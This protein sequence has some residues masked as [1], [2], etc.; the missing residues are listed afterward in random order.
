VRPVEIGPR[1]RVAR[2]VV[3]EILAVERVDDASVWTRIVRD[4]VLV[5][6]Q[7]FKPEFEVGV[8]VRAVGHGSLIAH[9]TS[10]TPGFSVIPFQVIRPSPD[11]SVERAGSCGP[12]RARRCSLPAEAE[13]V[14]DGLLVL[15]D[16]Q[17][18][19]CCLDRGLPAFAVGKRVGRRRLVELVGDSDDA[20]DVVDEV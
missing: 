9:L 8:L 2:A 11:C 4:L 6:A 1:G 13:V 19:P 10:P 16:G 17:G 3:G 12:D 18:P 20:V 14:F 7:V 15:F 5:L